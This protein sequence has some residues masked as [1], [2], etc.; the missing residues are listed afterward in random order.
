MIIE[1]Y[2]LYISTSEPA[3]ARNSNEESPV[4]WVNELLIYCS[5]S[6]AWYQTTMMESKVVYRL[7]NYSWKLDPVNGTPDDFS[8]NFS[9]N[10]PGATECLKRFFC[11][12]DRVS[13]LQSR[14]KAFAAVFR[15]MKLICTNGK[16]DAI[17]GR[18]LLPLNFVYHL[19]AQTAN[20]MVCP[21]KW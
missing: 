11:F 3:F 17:L 6:M 5:L 9:G 2:E 13:F 16:R 15:S 14:L 4:A 21:C 8:R 18:N 7:Q 10:V 20:R 19:H 12:S 1:S